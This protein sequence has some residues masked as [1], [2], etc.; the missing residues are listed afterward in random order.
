[1][2]PGVA[3]VAFGPRETAVFQLRKLGNFSLRMSQLCWR[4]GCR[5]SIAG[6]LVN[7]DQRTGL[8]SRRRGIC[9]PLGGEQTKHLA[10]LFFREYAEG[11]GEIP[12][13]LASG[14][15]VHESLGVPRFHGSKAGTRTETEIAL[16][17]TH[18]TLRMSR[19]VKKNTTG[20][21]ICQPSKNS[22]LIPI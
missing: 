22:G 9:G 8:V 11:F 7:A 15:F 13:E 14:Q 12:V 1:M 19:L 16:R 5:Q 18:M 6:R 20:G 21:A 4:S 3:G 17:R 10:Q 2:G